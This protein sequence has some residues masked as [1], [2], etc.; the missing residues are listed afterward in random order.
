[1]KKKMTV[2]AGLVLTVVLSMG[3]V[4]GT[5]AK[6]ISSVDSS[7]EARVAAWGLGVTVSTRDLFADSYTAG[8]KKI[9]ASENGDNILAP[10]LEGYY[11]F[12][13][14]GTAPEVA[15]KLSVD[16]DGTEYTGGTDELRELL[17]DSILFTLEDSHG[18]AV[19]SN[20][21]NKVLSVFIDQ[22]EAYYADKKFEAGTAL[23]NETYTIHWSWPFEA[24]YDEDDT[25]LGDAAATTDIKLN[26]N[27][28][29]TA[30]Q[31]QSLN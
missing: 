21:E 8:N 24:G 29:V 31:I 14:T 6:Y 16:L 18:N 19:N 4:A 30:Q 20:L 12:Q 28:K 9:A 11:D 13:F 2:L 17:E 7:D 23:D 15:Y 22:L 26:F 1:M 25:T 10:G 27:V 5:Y 3:S